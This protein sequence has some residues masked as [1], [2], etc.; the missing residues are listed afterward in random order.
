MASIDISGVQPADIILVRGDGM[1]SNVITS[2]SCGEFSHAILAV[3][4]GRCVEA[5]KPQVQYVGLSASLDH[6]TYGV[7]FRHKDIHGSYAGTICEYA[8][9]FAQKGTPYD[10]QGAMRAGV[11]SGCAPLVS[12]S[13]GA[14]I[15][16]NDEITKLGYHNRS[17][18]CSELVALVYSMAG[19]PVTYYQ[20]QQVTPGA[21]AKSPYLNRIKQ[22]VS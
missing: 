8:R 2:G 11:S 4:N 14:L 7:L 22:V 16:L 17:L 6:A 18:F 3:G 19:L 13:F 21:L 20:P 5:V 1:Q 12:T 9:Q 15:Q 10:T